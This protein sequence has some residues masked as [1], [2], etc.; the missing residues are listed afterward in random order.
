[1]CNNFYI[2]K[3]GDFISIIND[4]IIDDFVT[5]KLKTIFIL[6][7]DREFIDKIIMEDKV[8]FIC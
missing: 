5:N 6:I 8:N 7:R 3:N 1:M 4:V 2:S